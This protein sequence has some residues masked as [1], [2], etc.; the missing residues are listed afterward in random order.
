M[1]T[2]FHLDIR[3]VGNIT[4]LLLPSPIKQ[5]PIPQGDDPSA[6]VP[7]LTFETKM[8]EIMASRA[9]DP[10]PPEVLLRVSDAHVTGRTATTLLPLNAN[11]SHKSRNFVVYSYDIEY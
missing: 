5:A 7:Y 6:A 2:L 10:D 4:P 8:L 1:L 11:P 3:V 9:W